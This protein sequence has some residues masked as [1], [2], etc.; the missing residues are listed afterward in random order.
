MKKG[1]TVI[2]EPKDEQEAISLYYEI[3]GKKPIESV[4]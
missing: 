2:V 3:L 4:T 1:S